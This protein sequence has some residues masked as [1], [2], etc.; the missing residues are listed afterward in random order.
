MEE[1]GESRTTML[2]HFL[3]FYLIDR[4]SIFFTRDGKAKAK[5]NDVATL[6]SIIQFSAF[7][8]MSNDKVTIKITGWF[9]NLD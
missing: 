4:E 3:Y 7:I 6:P 8:E 1:D 5:G 9:S 2:D